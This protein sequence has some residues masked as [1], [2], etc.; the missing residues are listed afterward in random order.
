MC[1]RFEI[2]GLKRKGFYI[3]SMI[4]YLRKARWILQVPIVC[5]R[6]GWYEI[7]FLDEFLQESMRGLDDTCE[8]EAFLIGPFWKQ[9]TKYIS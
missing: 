1:T 9:I 5:P 4:E 7:D 6:K 8:A 2:F 3:V